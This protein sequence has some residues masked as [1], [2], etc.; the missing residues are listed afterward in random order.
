MW[1]KGVK[2]GNLTRKVEGKSL[3]GRPIRRWDKNMEA[4]DKKNRIR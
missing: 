2:Y 3:F 1:E 4:D